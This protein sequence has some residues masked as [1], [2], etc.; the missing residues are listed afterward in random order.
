[1]IATLPRAEFPCGVSFDKGKGLE[2]REA[3]GNGAALQLVK[4][5]IDKA[6]KHKGDCRDTDRCRSG[7]NSEDIGKLR[8]RLTALFLEE[9]EQKKKRT[10]QK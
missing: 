9:G 10:R 1:M 8:T 7:R 3:T 5:I 4:R 2:C 6:E